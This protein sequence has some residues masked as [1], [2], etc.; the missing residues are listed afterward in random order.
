MFL[1]STLEKF[2]L[3]NDWISNCFRS[4]ISDFNRLILSQKYD[5]QSNTL[6]PLDYFIFMESLSTIIWSWNTFGFDLKIVQSFRFLWHLAE[7]L[8]RTSE[9]FDRYDGISTLLHQ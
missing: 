8:D 5:K 3:S 4:K 2:V 9:N 7:F 1:Y 6:F